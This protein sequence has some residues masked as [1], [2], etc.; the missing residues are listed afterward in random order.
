MF[1][2]FF[3]S[4]SFC[5]VFS[6]LFYNLVPFAFCPF[7]CGLFCS[8]E[9]RL[10][11]ADNKQK[12]ST[13]THKIHTLTPT[14]AQ[15]CTCQKPG[16]GGTRQKVYMYVYT[17]GVHELFDKPLTAGATFLNPHPFWRGAFPSPP[18]MARYFPI[19][20]PYGGAFSY[21][22]RRAQE[23]FGNWLPL[24]PMHRCKR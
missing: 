4:L 3:L 18:L 16:G 17:S 13:Y 8:H 6:Y 2:F 23:N 9:I 7:V 15:T 21:H 10:K 14:N 1:P 12:I 20:T 22:T 11:H 19:P 24:I 5:F